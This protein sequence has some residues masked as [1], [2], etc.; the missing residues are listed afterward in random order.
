MVGGSEN[1]LDSKGEQQL[2]PNGADKFSATVGE[3][4]TRGAKVGDHMAH[5]GF[6]DRIGGM[7]MVFLE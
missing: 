4:S 1:L 7:R 3:E 2:D 6:T 5:E